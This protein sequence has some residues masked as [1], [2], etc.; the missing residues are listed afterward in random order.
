M[1][2]N[3]AI[4]LFLIISATSMLPAHSQSVDEALRDS[5]IRYAH[6]Y[7]GTPYRRGKSSPKAFDCSG[8]TSY[9]YRHFEY[10]L[11]RTADGQVKNVSKMVDKTEL[12][13]GDLVFFKGRNAKQ[14]RIGHVG[15]VVEADG[16]G[17]FKFIHASIKGVRITEGEN[18]YYK[19]RFVAAGR[20]VSDRPEPPEPLP[21]NI[22]RVKVPELVYP[23][24]QTKFT[25]TKKL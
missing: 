15:M 24:I 22:N 17:N 18:G 3:K 21:V 19:N 2:F 4:L 16:I 13:P 9:V 5:I 12:K 6:Q 8:F 23:E 25:K 14:N 20:V 10:N 7:M 11:S 1:T